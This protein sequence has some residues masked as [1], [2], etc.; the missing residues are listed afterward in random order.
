MNL[1]GFLVKTI[2]GNV[3][4]S[5]G[6]IEFFEKY[7]K[8]IVSWAQQVVPLHKWLKVYFKTGTFSIY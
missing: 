4:S 2:L 3:R 6:G 7:Y 1:S 5:R 8:N